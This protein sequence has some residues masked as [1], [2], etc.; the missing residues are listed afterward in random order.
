[1]SFPGFEHVPAYP[2]VFPVF[3][4]A[5]GVFLLV[6]MRHVRIFAAAHPGG[7]VALDRVPRR[8]WGVVQYAIVQVRMFRERRV[9]LMHYA[10]FLGST[11]L[12]I[13][14]AN[15]VTGGIIEAVVGWPLDGA[16]WALTIAIQNVV[17]LGALAGVAYAFERRLVS[18]PARLLFTRTA[19][20]IL[21]AILAV[22][23]T[24]FVALAFEAARWGDI[25]GAFAT[26]A[27]AVPL[28]S[29][30]PGVTEAGF[31]LF[32]WGHIAVLS[33]FLIYIPFNKH[34]H[35]YT[36]FVNVYLRK[37][38]PR[39]QLP[40]MDLEREDQTFGVRTL[41]DLGWKDVFDG[42][43]CTE[44]GRCT[45]ACPA[46]STGKPLDPR[47]LIMGIRGMAVDAE[48]GIDLIPNSPI[49][50]A[51]LGRDDRQP[52][53]ARLGTAI[54]DTAIPYDAVWDCVTCGAC[55]EACPVLI[56]HVDKIVGLRRNLVLEDSR[57]PPELTAAF[58][59]ME[60]AG[61]RGGCHARRGPTGRRVSRSTCRR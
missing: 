9:G 26:N 39:G 5:F 32:W 30:D 36:S 56:E 49:V 51:D 19:L 28:R 57:F 40:A 10:L 48:R 22:V 24:E 3:W 8:L 14:N 2:L 50:R 58:R 16:L 34:F 53:Q 52:D 47:A 45:E 1:V 60:Q 59:N 12:L 17:A 43:T 15:A 6:V 33:A 25:P 37:L 23:T 54:I 18:R 35:V 38:A 11:I 55:V 7:S 42:F 44:C 61:T 29:L 4:G 27:L 21:T 31:T 46:A 20:I 41:A 13:G